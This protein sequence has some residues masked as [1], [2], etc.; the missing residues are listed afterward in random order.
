VRLLVASGEPFPRGVVVDAS[1]V[2][3]TAGFPQEG[4]VERIGLDGTG[5]VRLATEQLGAHNIIADAGSIFWTNW[6][7][8]TVWAAPKPPQALRVLRP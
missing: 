3:W 4:R 2:Y 6:G 8:G 7:G 5:R 1:G